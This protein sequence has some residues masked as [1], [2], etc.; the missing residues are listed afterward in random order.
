MHA[1]ARTRAHAHS[2]CTHFAFARTHTRTHRTHRQRSTAPPSLPQAIIL[3]SLQEEAQAQAQAT[4]RAQS[5]QEARLASCC[6]P[7]LIAGPTELSACCPEGSTDEARKALAELAAAPHHLRLLKV[8]GD[9]HCLFRVVGASLVLTAAWGV[10]EAAAAL[11]AHFESGT[12]HQSSAEVVEVVRGLLAAATPFEALNEERDDAPA[13]RLVAALRRCAVAYMRAHTERFSATAACREGES[14][15][16]GSCANWEAYCQSMEDASQARYGGH[17]E[18]VALSESLRIRVDVY[19]TSALSGGVATYRLG[20]H[21]PET[22]P[23][24]R[25]VRRGLHYNLLLAASAEGE[26]RS[27]PVGVATMQ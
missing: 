5:E 3:A 26:A 1:C 12:L 20:E 2:T 11:E 13:Q 14:K 9:G 16:D 23:I 27:S 10:C 6:K 18:L 25:G 21:L 7:P 17:P 4:C 22:C 15:D 19:D 24:V 8:A